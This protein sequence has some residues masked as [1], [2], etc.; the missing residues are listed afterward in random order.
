LITFKYIKKV[1]AIGVKF[2]AKEEAKLLHSGTITIT[3]L[4][5]GFLWENIYTF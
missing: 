5:G 2:I 3:L 4:M 1:A